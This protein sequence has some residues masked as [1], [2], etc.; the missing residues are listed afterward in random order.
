MG[1]SYIGWMREVCFIDLILLNAF[2]CLLYMFDTIYSY[3]SMTLKK[4][5]IKPDTIVLYLKTIKVN[6][7]RSISKIDLI[8]LS[9]ILH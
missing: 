1:I 7:I 6:R 8:D 5:G 9:I 4:D 2:H 3:V